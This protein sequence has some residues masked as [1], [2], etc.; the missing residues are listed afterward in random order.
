[1]RERGA[2]ESD[3]FCLVSGGWYGM[4]LAPYVERFGDQLLVLFHDDVVT[5]P[6]EPFRAALQH[7]GA[8]AAFMPPELSRIV[9]SNQQGR[10]GRKNQLTVADR[11]ELWD[12]FRDDVAHLERMLGVD[13]SR[14]APEVAAAA[15]GE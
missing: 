5:N 13:L 2:P 9:F 15:G 6:A 8:D 11:R 4:S 10:A 12:Y 7:V 1:V 3:W 14:W